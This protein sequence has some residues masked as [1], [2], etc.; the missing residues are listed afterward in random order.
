MIS[1]EPEDCPTGGIDDVLNYELPK[2]MVD[3]EDSEP[4]PDD[5]LGADENSQVVISDP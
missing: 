5:D 1:K 4:H 2:N 3:Y